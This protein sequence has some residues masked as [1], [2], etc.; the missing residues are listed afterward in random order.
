M[1]STFGD[2]SVR[3]IS[4]DIDTD[5]LFRI[6]CRNDGEPVNTSSL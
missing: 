3:G 2:G 4:F 6:G 5:V 1:G